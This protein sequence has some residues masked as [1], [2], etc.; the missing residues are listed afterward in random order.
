MDSRKKKVYL[1]IWLKRIFAIYY[2]ISKY[3]IFIPLQREDDAA[4][5]TNNVTY[6]RN[7]ISDIRLS[8]IKKRATKNGKDVGVKSRRLR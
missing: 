4:V 2:G 6:L 8:N 7:A 1:L 3:R 5:V